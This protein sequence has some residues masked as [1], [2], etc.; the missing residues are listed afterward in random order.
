MWSFIPRNTILPSRHADQF[1]SGFRFVTNR[2]TR[3]LYLPIS[4]SWVLSCTARR[5]YLASAIAAISLAGVLIAEFFAVTATG[6]SEI[7]PAAL[8]LSQILL[9][10][11]IVGTALL[12]IAMWYF[13][14]NFDDSTWWRKGAWFFFLYVLLPVGPILYYFLV[15]RTSAVL[16]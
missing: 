15:Y 4:K 3:E 8:L 12:C 1:P 10:P 13:W 5:V 14:F 9:W 6:V 2:R 11:G 7:S 16:R